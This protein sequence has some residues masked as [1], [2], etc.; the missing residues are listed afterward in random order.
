MYDEKYAQTYGA[1]ANLKHELNRAR[2]DGMA[3]SFVRTMI[4]FS[5]LLADDLDNRSNETE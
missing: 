4:F 2:V 3:K 5:N 1:M